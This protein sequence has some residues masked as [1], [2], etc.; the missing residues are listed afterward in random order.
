MK[1]MLKAAHKIAEYGTLLSF[2]GMILAVSIQVVARFL[3]PSAPSWT[4]EI[5]RVFFIYMVAFG[6]STAIREKAFV[7]LELLYNYISKKVADKIDRMIQWAVTIF[8]LSMLYYSFEFL[9]IGINEQSPSLKISMSVVFAS[10]FV[11]MLSI[12]LF[13]FDQLLRTRNHN[14]LP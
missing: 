3:L 5:S 1:K 7:R 4:E 2:S 9:K 12:A 10:M 11:M 8:S 6:I 13:T 14:E